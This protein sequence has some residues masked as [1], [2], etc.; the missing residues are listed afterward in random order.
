MNLERYD[1]GECEICDTPMHEK[2]VKQ[3]FW[4]QGQ[5]LVIDEVP[6]G[7]C[8]RCGHRIVNAETGHRIAALIK[9]SERIAQ[10][11]KISVP[12]IKFEGEAAPA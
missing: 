12:E 4:V 6:A 8:P 10:A 1:Y 9:N 7:V 2:R 11:R 3:D 5:L